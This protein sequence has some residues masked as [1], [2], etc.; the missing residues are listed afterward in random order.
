MARFDG[1]ARYLR[2][3]HCAHCHSARL[4]NS[5]DEL[6]NLTGSCFLP[7]ELKALGLPR[8]HAGARAAARGAR[9]A[10][11]SRMRAAAG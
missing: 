3:V 5:A 10:C 7:G 8:A 1:L 4:C 11:A 6:H 2:E 9:R